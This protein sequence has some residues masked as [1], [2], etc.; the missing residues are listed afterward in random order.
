MPSLNEAAFHPEFSIHHSIVAVLPGISA[1]SW[2]LYFVNLYSRKFNK[3]HKLLPELNRSVLPVYIIHQTIIVVTGYYIIRYVSNGL[4]QFI[5]IVSLTILLSIPFYL[6]VKKFR[7]SR[8]LFG[9]RG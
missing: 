3:G 6:L 4:L 1:F 5:L 8:F 2:P 7:G 9:I